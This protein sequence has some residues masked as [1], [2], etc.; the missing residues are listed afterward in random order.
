M[1][2]HA[3]VL[4][5][6]FVLIYCVVYV[7]ERLESINNENI[8][9][10]RVDGKLFLLVKVAQQCAYLNFDGKEIDCRTRRNFLIQM[11]LHINRVILFSPSVSLNC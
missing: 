9:L 10:S 5:C 8:I 11:S 3:W 4:V 7:I 6:L 2:R 1:Q